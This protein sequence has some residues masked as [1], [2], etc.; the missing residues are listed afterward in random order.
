MIITIDGPAGAGKSTVAK[1]LAKQLGF[2]FLDT[3][4]MYRA[5]AWLSLHHGVQPE[6]QPDEFESLIA[7]IDIQ[8]KHSRIWINGH[9]VT[10]E[11]RTA[12]V[13]D[14]VSAVAD[15]AGVRQRLVF[16]QR[17]IAAKGNY[18][19]EGRDQGTVVFPDSRCKFFLTASDPERARRRA[20][21]L[22]ARG[23]E[24]NEQEILQSQVERDRRDKSRPVG[25]LRQ[26]SD[27]IEVITDGMTEQ[28]VVSK[29]ETIARQRLRTH[30]DKPNH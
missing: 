25:A 29:L 18:V 26:A 15:H 5:V 24:V 28:E 12:A 8:V 23:Q 3:G 16:Q 7:R 2:D 4:A 10:S 30:L 14:R 9:E 20:N 19:C 1:A 6:A 21:E 13:T 11:I 22:R 17:A 27:A